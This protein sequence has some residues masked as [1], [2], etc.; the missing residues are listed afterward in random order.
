MFA[1]LHRKKFVGGRAPLSDEEFLSQL[2]VRPELRRFAVATREALG[3]VCSVPASAFYPTDTPAATLKLLTFD[4]DDVGVAL[5]LEHVLGFS[6][7]DEIPRFLGWRFFWR[8]EAGPQTV[9][10]WCIQVAEYLQ[11]RYS[12]THVG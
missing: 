4:W 9:G 2:A 8:G 5:E 10:E 3:R 1:K 12:E 11:S 6:V 7:G